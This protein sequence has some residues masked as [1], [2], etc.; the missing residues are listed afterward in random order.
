MLQ[1]GHRYFQLAFSTIIHL[2]TNRQCAH[3]KGFTTVPESFRYMERQASTEKSGCPLARQQNSLKLTFQLI[4]HHDAFDAM[5]L[6]TALEEDER[7]QSIDVVL[8][9][10]S[11][12]PLDIDPGEGH[13]P[14]VSDT[15]SSVALKIVRRQSESRPS[16][17]QRNHRLLPQ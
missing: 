12:L 7:R 11:L 17:F 15:R 13:T 9:D 6:L 1:Y 10:K 8:I 2:Q 16:P 14:L 5:N 3:C 4:T